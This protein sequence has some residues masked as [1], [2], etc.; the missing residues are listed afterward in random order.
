MLTNF[1]DS[2]K[3]PVFA[4]STSEMM[5]GYLVDMVIDPDTGIFKALWINSIDG[6]KL[7]VPKDIIYWNS[8]K[9]LIDDVNILSKA[10]D[11]PRLQKTFEKECPILGAWVY[12]HK[13]SK[14][15]GKVANFMFDTISPRILSLEIKSGWFGLKHRLIPQGQIDKI[16]QR[17]IWVKQDRQKIKGTKAALKEDIKS[18]NK[19]REVEIK[20]KIDKK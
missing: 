17:G 1:N 4:R 13:Q 9:I 10:E 2:F 18:L 12:E 14:P 15:F 11:L 5:I 16:D 8:Q 3:T 7:L 19:L 20:Q 6:Q